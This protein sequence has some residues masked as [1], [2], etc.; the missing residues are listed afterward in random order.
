MIFCKLQDDN[1]I[2]FLFE[3]QIRVAATDLGQPRSC[4]ADRN[5]TVKVQ[6]TRNENPPVFEK[7]GQYSAS[8]KEDLGTNNRVTSVKAA[9]RD[10]RVCTTT[11]DSRAD[12]TLT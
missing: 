1:C 11:V 2:I 6:V 4:Q 9:D 8:I 3:Y 10:T 12:S 7:E 5:A